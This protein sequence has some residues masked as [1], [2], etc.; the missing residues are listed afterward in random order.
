MHDLLLIVSVTI[1]IFSTYISCE[2]RVNLMSRPGRCVLT[3]KQLLLNCSLQGDNENNEQLFFKKGKA[4]IRSSE[5]LQVR[6]DNVT[7]SIIIPETN[8]QDRGTYTCC[9]SLCSDETEFDSGVFEVGDVPP[10]PLYF[11]C[12][13][14]NGGVQ[15]YFSMYDSCVEWTLQ[16]RMSAEEEDPSRCTCTNSVRKSQHCVDF[17]DEDNS[18]RFLT[19]K[20][21]DIHEK[22]IQTTCLLA[23]AIRD[24]RYTIHIEGRSPYGTSSFD[25]NITTNITIEQLG[26]LRRFTVKSTTSTTATLTWYFPNNP[27]YYKAGISCNITY[28]TS[29]SVTELWKNSKY[30]QYVVEPLKPFQ[31]YMIQV[32]C[33]F[34]ESRYWSRSSTAKFSTK[35]DVPMYGPQGTPTSYS[36]YLSKNQTCTVAIYIKPPA[37]DTINGILKG[38]ELQLFS[39]SNTSLALLTKTYPVKSTLIIENIQGD[40]MG[41]YADISSLTVVG[42]SRASL[43]LNL[44]IKPTGKD[45]LSVESVTVSEF[46]DHHQFLVTIQHLTSLN[47]TITYIYHWCQV[48]ARDYDC[49]D[50][51]VVDCTANYDFA[52]SK[53][54]QMKI[55]IAKLARMDHSWVFGA[56]IAS[57]VSRGGIRWETCTLPYGW[58]N[59]FT[60]HSIEKKDY[61]YALFALFALPLSILVAVVC[62]RNKCRNRCAAYDFDLPTVD[63]EDVNSSA[64]RTSST[65]KPSEDTTAEQ[66]EN[67]NEEMRNSEYSRLHPA[68]NAMPGDNGM[69]SDQEMSSFG[70]NNQSSYWE[71]ENI[72]EDT[73]QATAANETAGSQNVPHYTLTDIDLGEPYNGVDSSDSNRRDDS[74]TSQHS[75]EQE[76]ER[77][78]TGN[79]EIKNSEYSR[80]HPADNTVSDGSMA[81]SDR[82]LCPF[83]ESTTS[84]RRKDNNI[85][86]D[87]TDENEVS[88]DQGEK[89]RSCQKY[90]LVPEMRKNKDSLSN[91]VYIPGDSRRTSG[92]RENEPYRRSSTT[93][94]F[95][96]PDLKND[97]GSSHTTHPTIEP[98]DDDAGFP[99]GDRSVLADDISYFENILKDMEDV[100]L[101][102]SLRKDDKYTIEDKDINH[103]DITVRNLSGWNN[104]TQN[105]PEQENRTKNLSNYVHT[106]PGDTHRAAAGPTSHKG[107]LVRH[108]IAA[109]DDKFLGDKTG[110][111]ALHSQRVPCILNCDAAV[112]LQ[113]TG[114]EGSKEREDNEYCS[115]Q[116]DNAIN[117]PRSMV[118]DQQL[119]PP[120]GG[121]TRAGE[122]ACRKY[123]ENEID[124]TDEYPCNELMNNPSGWNSYKKHDLHRKIED[125]NHCLP[126]YV[127]FPGDTHRSVTS[128][129][130]VNSDYYFTCGTGSRNNIQEHVAYSE[131]FV[132]EKE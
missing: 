101:Q 91:Y 32:L 122:V 55:V 130:S 107:K 70:F 43:H 44:D 93:D 72:P 78:G 79:E 57:P 51:G 29:Q 19:R 14:S 27:A 5:R 21:Q 92:H 117:G 48:T 1:G 113:E 82:E 46:P 112:N 52:Y 94:V 10:D 54:T 74:V 34:T 18:Y 7:S 125:E 26:P 61:L 77:R 96:L 105:S 2:T 11:H 95:V 38:Y 106:L 132:S 115:F 120:K 68:D 88:N 13:I 37:P 35:Q 40:T 9:R 67:M 97:Y 4:R 50:R 6:N 108:R 56:S 31:N 104:C 100:E 103:L 84:P 23:D 98:S 25:Y 17:N 63:S 8:I 99:P 22:E 49:K 86:A 39:S 89:N 110:D 33:R 42:K 65:H 41:L 111:N 127:S 24:E 114:T 85:D 15:C 36:M 126:N 83:V 59:I 102:I 30:V 58:R 3:G 47:K 87:T 64:F 53:E 116:R 119:C 76:T 73:I 62:K 66:W 28:N 20:C 16:Y 90:D 45:S 81:V 121:N 80:L 69:T 124:D 131:H 118:S 109:S 71:S 60:S 12:I 128:T 123:D 129:A 75:N